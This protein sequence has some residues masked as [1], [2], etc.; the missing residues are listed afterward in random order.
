M[1]FIE[2]VFIVSICFRILCYLGDIYSDNTN[3]KI[4]D[5]LWIILNMMVLIYFKLV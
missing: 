5:L 3:E 4:L 2:K 1:S